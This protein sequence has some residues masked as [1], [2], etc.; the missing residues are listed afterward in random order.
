MLRNHPEDRTAQESNGQPGAEH[1]PQPQYRIGFRTASA[2]LSFAVV[3]A[4]CGGF[5]F[6]TGGG[7]SKVK[8]RGTIVATTPTGDRDILVFVLQ[9]KEVEGDCRFPELPEGKSSSKSAILEAGETEF[10]FKATGGGRLI[11][12]FLLDNPGNQADGRIDDG[13]PVAILDDPDCLL[14]DVSSK[15]TVVANGLRLNF[16]DDPIVGFP[17]A[18][19]ATATTLT[20][21]R[22][23]DDD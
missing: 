5:L 8:V 12:A 3:L 18:G 23:P 20:V 21:S 9:T 17:D 11:L 1:A 10:D 2:V 13:D 14:E 16:S 15:D 6:D 4:G 19:R 7:G 22:N